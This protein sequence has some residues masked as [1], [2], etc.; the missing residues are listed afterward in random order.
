MNSVTGTNV[1]IK[2]R[3]GDEYNGEI[4]KQDS[5]ILTLMTENGK[6]E[7]IRSNIRSIELYEYDG[8]FAFA[9]SHV[10]RYFFGPS[11]IPTLNPQVV[12]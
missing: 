3:N 6:I 10:T 11:A 7:L 8:R 12:C 5:A 1:I 9:N 2:L 4:H